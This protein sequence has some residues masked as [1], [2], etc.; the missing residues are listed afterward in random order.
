MK[1]QMMGRNF[2]FAGACM[3]AACIWASN[4]KAATAMV[5]YPQPESSTDSRYQYDWVVLRTALEKSSASFGSFDLKPSEQR[6]PQARV[7]A[8][9]LLPNSGINI[10]VR[11][12]SAILEQKFRPIRIPV[13][14]GMLGYRVFLVRSADL[15]QFSKVKTLADLTKFKVGQGKGWADIPILSAA[16][17]T[18][19]E[20][21]NYEGL[22]SMLQL[23]RFDIF[24]RSSD[25]AYHE[26]DERKS[27][28]PDLAVE[29]TLLL[30]YPL[31]RYFFVR[32]D[33]DGD[34]LA[35]RIEAGMEIMVKDGTLNKLFLEHKGA[36]IKRAEL[37]KRTVFRI[38]NPELPSETPLNRTELWYDPLTGK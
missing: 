9:A 23:G 8:E 24:S 17:F 15:P 38:P 33:A 6:M 22:F 11:A 27:G 21:N 13:D 12:T 7:T 20:G 37:N 25:E 31:P 35:K 5:V 36:I 19:V 29:P 28:Q 26:Y 18:V 10:F 4:A 2:L 3:L 1:L 32:R 34:Q 16:K 14:R 30:Y